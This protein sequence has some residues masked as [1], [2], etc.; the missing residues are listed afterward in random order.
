MGGGKNGCCL[1]ALNA[2]VRIQLREYT[3]IAMRYV[4]VT[5]YIRG[6]YINLQHDATVVTNSYTCYV[7]LER[8]Q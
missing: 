3:T 7:P 1:P 2:K 8:K 6:C 4:S 5:I